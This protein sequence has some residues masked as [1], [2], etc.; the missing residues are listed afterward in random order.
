MVPVL[1]LH[2]ALAS[3]AAWG[4]LARACGARDWITPDLPGHG[5]APDFDGRGRFM[6]AALERVQAAMPDGAVDL[7]GHSYGAV[8]ALRLL[9]DLPERFRSVTLIEPVLFAAAE[10]GARAR[11]RAEMVPFAK[12]LAGDDRDRAAEV[13][14]GLWGEGAWADLPQPIRRHL[15]ARIHLIQATEPE[16][17]DD[18]HGILPRLPADREVTV[19]LR[20]DP[21]EIVSAIAQGLATRLPK[22]RRY[23]M[24][25][26]HMLPQTAV[27]DVAKVLQAA[28]S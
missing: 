3:S 21:P 19:I 13:F 12:A 2:C 6:D 25:Q 26:G 17:M 8:L 10:P 5:A 1:A 27:S 4:P 22:L 16:V 20:Q 7:V 14:H 11:H 23:G 18:I 9:V 28:W 24:G 15:A